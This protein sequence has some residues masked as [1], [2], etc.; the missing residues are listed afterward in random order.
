M[1]KKAHVLE[2][3]QYLYRFYWIFIET[4]NFFR[5]ILFLQDYQVIFLSSRLNKLMAKTFFFIN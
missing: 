1:E 5:E 3:K 2:M 4:L